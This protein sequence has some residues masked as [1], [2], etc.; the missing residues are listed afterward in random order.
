MLP[1]AEQLPQNISE[2]CPTKAKLLTFLDVTS[3]D[4]ASQQGWHDQ[5]A[6]YSYQLI[7]SN[8]DDL[9]QAN[10]RQTNPND[11]QP[12]KSLNKSGSILHNILRIL[13]ECRKSDVSRVLVIED[14]QKMSEDLED[15]GL[16]D[17]A[18]FT[19]QETLQ[20]NAMPKLYFIYTPE[21]ARNTS[22]RYLPIRILI[23]QLILAYETGVP[24]YCGETEP[25]GG[26]YDFSDL[27]KIFY[28]LL[29]PF[30]GVDIFIHAMGAG[31]DKFDRLEGSITM[32][33]LD[34]LV[35]N[36]ELKEKGV[37]INILLSPPLSKLVSKSTR[38]TLAEDYFEPSEICKWWDVNKDFGGGEYFEADGEVEAQDTE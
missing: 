7:K 2:S 38:S 28:H 15:G 13:M 6:F 24:E 31:G 4:E 25:K 23:H 5:L 35:R 16:V 17:A 19:L 14:K 21:V 32:N 18:A 33:F 11:E 12:H 3:D 8:L 34:R 36:E 10:L 1:D 37:K 27:E 30:P 22:G 9:R 29:R 26:I 20:G